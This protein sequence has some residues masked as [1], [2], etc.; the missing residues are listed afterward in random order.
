[1]IDAPSVL[2]TPHPSSPPH[3]S[4]LLTPPHLLAPRTSSPL[5]P[6]RPSNLLICHPSNHLTPRSPGLLRRL[7]V[8]RLRP[9]SEHRPA[10]V[11]HHDQR[12]MGLIHHPDL[13]LGPILPSQPLVSRLVVWLETLIGA[14]R[15]QPSDPTRTTLIATTL[16]PGTYVTTQRVFRPHRRHHSPP[17]ALVSLGHGYRR[18]P[19]RI[20]EVAT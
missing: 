2:R 6:S 4:N 10:A 9:R 14:A 16:H 11:L 5:E 8:Y 20:T 17:N 3:P 1:M 12:S 19:F 7:G 13:S 18:P 15:S